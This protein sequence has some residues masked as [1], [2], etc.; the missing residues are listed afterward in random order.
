MKWVVSLWCGMS[1]TSLCA[2]G[3]VQAVLYLVALLQWGGSKLVGEWA[4]LRNR[5]VQL[6]VCPGP[7]FP[8]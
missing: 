2:F 3:V 1:L 7:F 6:W 8:A 5:I 4:S